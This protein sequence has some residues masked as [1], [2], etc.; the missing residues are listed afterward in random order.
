MCHAYPASSSA[1]ILSRGSNLPRLLCNSIFFWPPPVP[2]RNDNT[3]ISIR[4]VFLGG[5][6]KDLCATQHKLVIKPI[7]AAAIRAFNS[8]LTSFITAKLS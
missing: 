8:A 6:Q 2:Q 3:N 1:P 7:W 4:T 5:D